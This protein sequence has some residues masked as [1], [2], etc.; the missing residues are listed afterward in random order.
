MFLAYAA[1]HGQL[2]E[3]RLDAALAL[4][5]IAAP[6]RLAAAG[7]LDRMASSAIILE[8]AWRHLRRAGRAPGGSPSAHAA[9][10]SV[11]LAALRQATVLIHLRAVAPAQQ[12]SAV[13][14][15]RREGFL[16]VE[17]LRP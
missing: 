10:Q 2:G 1:N 17:T 16:Q 7:H 6:L 13:R 9:L 14:R 11:M 5:R 8:V 15:A 4:E 12:S 3:A